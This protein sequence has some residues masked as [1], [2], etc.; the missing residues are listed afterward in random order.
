MSTGKFLDCCGSPDLARRKTLYVD[1]GG[2]VLPALASKLDGRQR[3]DPEGGRRAGPSEVLRIV[4][5]CG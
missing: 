5:G 2:R 1:C 4:A 3:S